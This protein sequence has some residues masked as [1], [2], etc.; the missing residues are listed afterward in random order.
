MNRTVSLTKRVKTDKGLRYCQVV[1]ASNGRIT[2]DLVLVNGRAERHPEGAYYLEWTD[3]KRKR[4]SVGKNATDAAAKQHRQEQLLAARAAGLTVEDDKPSGRLL[5]NAAAAYLAEIE[6]QKKPATHDAYSLAVNYFLDSCSKQTLEEIDRTDL[7]HF[8][9]FL[10]KRFSPYS[11]HH[12][13]GIAVSF[14]KAQ[15]I[16][17]LV[18]KDDWPSYTL[19]EPEVYEREELD[20][21]FSACT[22]DE[23]LVF[24]FFLLTGMRE[25]E[26]AYAT[27]RSVNFAQGTVS[28]KHNPEFGWTPKAYKEREI[29]VPRSLM[30][31]LKVWKEKKPAGCELLFPRAGCKPQNLFWD[32]CQVIAKRAGLN[33]KEWWLHRFRATFATLR[34][35]SGI[36]LRT[37]QLWLGH[38]DIASTMR[39]LKPNRSQALRDKIE[40]EFG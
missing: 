29:P 21:F 27:W 16:S 14:L 17:G 5:V 11:V 3:G 26:V 4:L 7:L 8:I 20:K 37:V 13:F 18:K 1:T 25:K 34:L 10:R 39:Y 24:Q 38:T 15:G 35:Q 6:A 2:P 19:E 36:D 40:A 23:R 31:A 33:P 12:R 30:D 32:I 28:V 9:T 22:V